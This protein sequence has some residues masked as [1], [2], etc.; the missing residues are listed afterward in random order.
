[1]GWPC[2]DTRCLSKSLYSFPPQL[3]EKREDI[4]TVSWVDTKAGRNHSSV[5]VMGRKTQLGELN[6]TLLRSD[7]KGQKWG[8]CVTHCL[9]LSF[10]LRVMWDCV[11]GLTEVQVEDIQVE[12]VS[13]CFLTIAVNHRSPPVWSG[14]IFPYWSHASFLRSPP[15]LVWA[16]T[17]LLWGSA[18]WTS[19]A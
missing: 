5:T 18:P 16:S 1:M 9:C 10:H 4:R 14:T 19:Q 7:T 3:E 11:K 12:D 8:L 17:F 2:L 15:C 13:L 6:S